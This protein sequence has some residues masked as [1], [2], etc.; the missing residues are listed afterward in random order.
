MKPLRALRKKLGYNRGEMA[1][2]LNM[3]RPTYYNTEDGKR[4]MKPN[5]IELMEELVRNLKEGKR[6]WKPEPTNVPLASTTSKEVQFSDGLYTIYT[7]TIYVK[8]L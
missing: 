4:E 8:H 3:S 1:K 7:T 5:E 2:L 6:I